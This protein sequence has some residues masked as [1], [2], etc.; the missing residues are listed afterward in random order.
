ML[1]FFRTLRKTEQI[2]PDGRRKP[3][4]GTKKT[5]EDGKRKTE[6][7][8]TLLNRKPNEYR[9]QSTGIQSHFPAGIQSHFPAGSAFLF[10]KFPFR[11]VYDRFSELP[12]SPSSGI[13]R[14]QN[15]KI[16][17]GGRSEDHRPPTTTASHRRLQDLPS[18]LNC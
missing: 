1:G 3:E 7:R 13:L 18:L 17:S 10:R 8:S 12:P 6:F 4:D 2:F 16:F 14:L 15:K 11:R 5:T 9:A